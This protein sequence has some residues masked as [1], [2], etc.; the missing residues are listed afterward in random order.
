MSDGCAATSA[1][2]RL[3]LAVVFALLVTA[4]STIKLGYESLPTL[5]LWQA[6]SYLALDDDQE[7]ALK[8]HAN[9]LL[10]WHR[11]DQLPVY[12]GLLSRVENEMRSEVTVDQ[13]TGWR[14]SILAAWTPL[15]DRLAPA[16]AE[17]A[18]GLRTEQIDHLRR[19]LAKANDKAA[20]DF[21]SPDPV[22]RVDARVKRWTERAEGFLGDLN[23]EQQRLVRATAQA[24]SADDGAWWQQRLARQRSVVDLLAALSAER[25]PVEVAAERVR[26]LLA[27]L[28]QPVA[29]TADGGVGD[30]LT[31]QLIAAA[32]PEQLKR[33][34]ARVD[35][36]RQDVVVLARR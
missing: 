9:T 31:A 11:Q 30:R 15:A 33:A 5:V 4:C 13:V 26:P 18:I 8:R 34:I 32:T 27:S 10:R 20:R 17:I 19:A 12:A 25:P 16:V 14:K 23:A 36:Y 3:A 2:A 24:A 7:A 22:K 1:R 35:G 21:R 28:F 29:G 6:D